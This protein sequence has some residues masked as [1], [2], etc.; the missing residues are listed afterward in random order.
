MPWP[1]SLVVAF[2]HLQVS[3]MA[4]GSIQVARRM[5][6]LLG[7]QDLPDRPGHDLCSQCNRHLDKF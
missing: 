7:I 5:N 4:H 6:R 3:S 1:V 2:H